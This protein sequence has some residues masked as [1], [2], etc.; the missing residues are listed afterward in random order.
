MSKELGI[1]PCC[2]KTVYDNQLYV[3][4]HTDIYHFSCF[5]YAMYEKKSRLVNG[6]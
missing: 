5:N 2:K 4:K 1:C 6:K 3:D